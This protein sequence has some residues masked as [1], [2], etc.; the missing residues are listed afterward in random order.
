MNMD[1]HLEHYNRAF[2]FNY[3]EEEQL[4]ILAKL[5]CVVPCVGYVN[6]TGWHQLCIDRAKK[7][8]EII[9]DV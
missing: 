7:A 8:L 1:N 5:T 4:E 2:P 6:D 3:T 9:R